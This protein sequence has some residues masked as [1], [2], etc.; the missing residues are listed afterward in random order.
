[1]LSQ[2]QVQ[3]YCAYTFGTIWWIFSQ[4]AHFC[5]YKDGHDMQRC[6]GLMKPR[7]ETITGYLLVST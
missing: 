1:M 2:L 5:E 6:Q 7:S 4:N 3:Y